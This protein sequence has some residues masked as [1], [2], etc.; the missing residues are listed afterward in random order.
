[1]IFT[2]ITTALYGDSTVLRYRFM[3]FVAL[4]IA[5]ICAVVFTVR[6][7]RSAAGNC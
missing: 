6:K 5:L 4:G 1:M 2:N 7:K 3:S